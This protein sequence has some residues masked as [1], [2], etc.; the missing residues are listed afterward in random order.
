MELL[1][2]GLI[3]GF[4]GGFF[5]VGGGM[6]LVPLLLFS[7]F[8]MKSAVSISIM[9]MIFTSVFGTF[10]NFQKNKNFLKDSI[11]LG[12]GGFTGGLLSG[13]IISNVSNNFLQYLFLFIVA[14]SIFRL[15]VVNI[16]H[17]YKP[18]KQNNT[19]LFIFGFFI[20]LIAMSIGVG[21]SIMLLPILASFMYYNL[22]DASSM[23]LFFVVFS[24]IA[25][26]ISLSINNNML[27]YEGSIVAIAS[28]LGVFLG[29]KAKYKVN[30]KSYKLYL[31][32]MYL[33]IFISVSYK[34]LS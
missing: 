4:I 22:K 20:G 19:L 26:F 2:F 18:N 17:S 21:G 1:L 6:I 8:D 23:G 10:L 31:L 5:G 15:S 14:F 30:I 28:L 33:I 13:L 7:N 11:I 24:S 12:I 9:Q 25:G 29:I 16:G 3:A 32:T 27:Y 34:L